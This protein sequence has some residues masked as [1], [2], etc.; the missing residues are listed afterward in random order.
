MTVLIPNNLMSLKR[1]YDM[2]RVALDLARLERD[3][4]GK[5]MSLG[6]NSHPVKAY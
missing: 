6:E 2:E 1:M 4:E 5:I 3:L